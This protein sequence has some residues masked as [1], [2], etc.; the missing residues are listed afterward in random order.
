MVES[1]KEEFQKKTI[2]RLALQTVKG[3][4]IFDAGDSLIFSLIF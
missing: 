2:R 4:T 3:H 1:D